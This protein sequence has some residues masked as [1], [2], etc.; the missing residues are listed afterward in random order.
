MCLC[1]CLCLC[2]SETVYV[3]GLLLATVVNRP[4]RFDFPKLP[5]PVGDY[6]LNLL[7]LGTRLL[8]VLLCWHHSKP[9]GGV[10]GLIFAGYV[11]QVSQSPYS[12]IVY[13]VTTYSKL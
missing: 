3:F 5:L 10:L 2:A 8:K 4:L 1:L 12:I 11:P 6:E 13:F 9:E 7:I